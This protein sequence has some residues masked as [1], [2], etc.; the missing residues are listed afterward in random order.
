MAKEK[1]KKSSYGK[2]LG[3]CIIV[4][5][6]AAFLAWLTGGGFGFGG[7]GLPFGLGGN[8]NGNGGGY[9]TDN[10]APPQDDQNYSAYEPGGYDTPEEPEL[11]IRVVQNTIYHGEREI[12]IDD[13]VPLFEELNQPGLIW[14]LRDEQA[15]LETYENVKAILLENEIVFTER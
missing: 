9:A 7:I 3:F 12:T 1:K 5:C 10:G 13:L 4:G 6:L 15:I 11:L 14:E 8:G 2:V